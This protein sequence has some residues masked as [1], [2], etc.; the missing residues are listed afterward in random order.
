MTAPISAPRPRSSGTGS[1]SMRVTSMPRPRQVAA[2]SAPMKPGADDRDPARA[3][4][5]LGPDG[6]AV[7]EGAERV[8]AGEV[9]GAGQPPRRTRRWRSR[10]R[11]RAA[12]RRRPA[13][14]VRAARSSPVARAA[15]VP[16]RGR[17]RRSTRRR[18]RARWPPG[19]A[20]RRAPAWT[21]AGGR[22]A[23]RLV[24]DEV[25]RAV[26]ALRP[27]LLGGPEPARDAPT[28]TMRAPPTGSCQPSI[29]MACLGQRRTASSTLAR[30]S[31]AGSSW[32]T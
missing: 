19:A 6:E 13:A 12:G 2:T 10:A 28:M 27:Q 17:G 9:V 1:A 4:V 14:R 16:G 21:A 5:E 23:V 22:R 3:G 11:R 7:V 20:C 8:D 32:S 29:E 31:S 26:V 15:E 30:S 24:A 18:H 25:D